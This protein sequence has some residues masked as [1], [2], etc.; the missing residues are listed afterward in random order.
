MAKNEY[1]WEEIAKYTRYFFLNNAALH[2]ITTLFTFMSNG[3][4]A[5]M[6]GLFLTSK[7][8]LQSH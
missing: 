2:K 4:E 5:L 1:T 7:R 6:G 8:L 3:W